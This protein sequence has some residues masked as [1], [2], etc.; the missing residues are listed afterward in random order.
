MLATVLRLY[1]R[2]KHKD[3]KI[4]ENHLLHHFVLARL[5]SSSIRGKKMYIFESLN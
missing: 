3:A 1:F 4:F 2:P 5:A